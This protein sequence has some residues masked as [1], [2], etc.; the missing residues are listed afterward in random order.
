MIKNFISVT[1]EV[2][3]FEQLGS[4]IQGFATAVANTQSKIMVL[5][6]I[7]KSVID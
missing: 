5:K 6:L 2:I 4:E 1:N 7:L 3:S